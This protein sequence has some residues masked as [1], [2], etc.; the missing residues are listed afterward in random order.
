M[1]PA[2]VVERFHALGL[3]PFRA[4]QVC[5]WIYRRG[6][7]RFD[8]MSDLSRALRGEL[9]A[10]FSISWPEVVRV[11]AARDG[12]RKYELRMQDGARIEC[13]LI[14]GG[15]R[16]T[17][18]ISSQVGCA[19]ACTFCR[20]GEMGLERNLTPHEMLGQLAVVRAEQ[21][22]WN[23]PMNHVFM[24]MGEPL[25]NATALVAALSIMTS[26]DGFAISPRRITVSTAGFLP[27]LATLEA[28]R[29]GT[30]LALSITAADD[31]LRDVLMPINRR[32]PAAEVV[33]AAAR[34][35]RRGGIRTTV[36]YVML[37]GVNDSPDHA[38]RLA[39]LLA[40]VS[41]KVN[42]IPFNPYPGSPYRRPAADVVTAFQEV[43]L[44]R[45]I[46]ANIRK[47]HAEDVLA[48]CGQLAAPN[49]SAPVAPALERDR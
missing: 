3:P 6:A 32:F 22:L 31:A 26:A 29:L 7:H 11:V 24:G 20:T 15:K 4:R 37:A 25:H 41:V 47:T 16:P 13:V 12:S 2:R 34:T 27:G 17:L 10:R 39:D 40:T 46:H 35:N 45:A 33:R 9:A 30:K 49:G 19:L 23:T 1:S 8:D 48:A 18:C 42:L 38:R 36:A 44:A 21:R 28:A 14:A 5:R 43:L